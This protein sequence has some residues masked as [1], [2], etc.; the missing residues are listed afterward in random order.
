[1]LLSI[2]H[3]GFACLA[4][5]AK[6]ETPDFDKEVWDEPCQKKKKKKKQ[7]IRNKK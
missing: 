6:D 5:W 1:M 7:E 4:E 3:N 2:F